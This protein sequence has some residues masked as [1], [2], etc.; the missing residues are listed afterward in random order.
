[1]SLHALFLNSK[2]VISKLTSMQSAMINPIF[3]SKPVSE[4]RKIKAISNAVNWL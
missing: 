3:C 4:K 1:M 2:G